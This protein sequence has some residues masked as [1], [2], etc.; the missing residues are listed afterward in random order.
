MPHRYDDPTQPTPAV[1]PSL[2]RGQAVLARADRR[3]VLTL[4]VAWVLAMVAVSYSGPVA[5]LVEDTE[6]VLLDAAFRLRGPRDPDPRIAVVAIDQAA[7]DRF[8]RF[9]FDRRVFADALVALEAG[10]TAA[11]LLDLVFSEPAGVEQDG[12]LAEALESPTTASVLGHFF[13]TDARGTDEG[14]GLG[15][16][17]GEPVPSS[18]E[19]GDRTLL[20]A[21]GA[22]P[23]L[24]D[25]LARAAG[26][27]LLNL[28]GERGGVVR[29]AQLVL[30]HEGRHV[31]TRTAA[32][33]LHRRST[34]YWLPLSYFLD[35]DV[36]ATFAWTDG[37]PVSYVNWGPGQPDNGGG[38]N[39]CAT[40]DGSGGHWEDHDCDG[41]SPRWTSRVCGVR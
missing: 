20:R 26:A 9:P 17:P 25:L 31:Q 38:G 1:D 18:L 2:A 30:E 29:R 15:V 36:P 34:R 5:R 16:A 35:Q 3:W 21:T 6:G 39:D 14:R 11:V 32:H 13:Y 40:L 4:G 12:P 19:P 24:P 23:P 27:G 7:I 37:S 22:Q 33:R 41:G 28:R 8:G 10:G